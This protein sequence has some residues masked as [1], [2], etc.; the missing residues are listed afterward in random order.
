MKMLIAKI[1]S[2]L[3]FLFS[4]QPKNYVVIFYPVLYV[5]RILTV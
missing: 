2:S 5:I 1:S 3:D 4:Q